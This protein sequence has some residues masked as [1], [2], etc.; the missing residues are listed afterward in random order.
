MATTQPARP[1]PLHAAP[2]RPRNGLGVAALVIGVASLVAAISFFWFPLAPI[3]ALVGLIIGIVTLIRRRHSGA[4]NTGQAA[5]SS[6][7]HGAP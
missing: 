2:D 7:S 5:T 3:A 4:T 1:T 6:P